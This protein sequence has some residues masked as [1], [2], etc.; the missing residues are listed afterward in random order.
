ME[1]F[2]EII[3]TFLLLAAVVLLIIGFIHEPKIVKAETPYRIFI[4]RWF[5]NLLKRIRVA[6]ARRIRSSERIMK[7]LDKPSITEKITKEC[8]VQGVKI[9][10]TWRNN[11]CKAY[12][13]SFYI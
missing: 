13:R 11:E 3:K 7:W 2:L 8:N 4:R 12:C 1:L 10:K 6:L 5:E 9:I